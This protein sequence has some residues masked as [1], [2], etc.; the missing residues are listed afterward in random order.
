VDHEA[1]LDLSQHFNW[2][3]WC[4]IALRVKMRKMALFSAITTR[5][6]ADIYFHSFRIKLLDKK[7]PQM[8]NSIN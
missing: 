2:P 7:T 3:Y 8:Y 1:I 4:Q 5:L 6:H